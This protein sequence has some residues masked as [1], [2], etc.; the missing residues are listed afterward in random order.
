MKALK[1]PWSTGIENSMNRP[2]VLSLIALISYMTFVFYLSSQ[3]AEASAEI[4]IL[5]IPTVVMHVG[6]YAILGLL[7]NLVMT[8]IFSKTSKRILY[9]S[10]LSS[11]YGVTDEIHQYF[12]PTRCFDIYDIL[13]DTA[14]GVMGAVFLTVLLTVLKVR[15]IGT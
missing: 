11:F 13:A 5:G 1:N 14:G 6:E 3:P 2:L 10:V 4:W 8:Q 15:K 9:S 7:M 12:V